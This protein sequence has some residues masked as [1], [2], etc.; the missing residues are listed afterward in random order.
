MIFC[1]DHI[2]RLQ[3]PAV[4]PTKGAA[5]ISGTRTKDR[6]NLKAAGH[7]EIRPHA[8]V[9]FGKADFP[10]ATHKKRTPERKLPNVNRKLISDSCH[11]ND[12]ILHR[13]KCDIAEANF[14]GG[15]FKRVVCQNICS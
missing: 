10:S 12:A 8:S 11:C 14:D 7:R 4:E 15:T 13:L 1:F 3:L 6:L 2:A 5:Q 9:Y